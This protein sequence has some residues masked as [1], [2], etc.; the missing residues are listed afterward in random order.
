LKYPLWKVYTGSC[1]KR[2]EWALPE[3][4]YLFYPDGEDE[5]PAG[6]YAVGYV[7]GGRD[8]RDNL[9]G[10]MINYIDEHGY[11]IFGDA[12]EEYPLNEINGSD[13][14]GYLT[15]VLISVRKKGRK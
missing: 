8:K 15:R 5:R 7:R 2:G 4:Y 11:K 9:Y 3:R 1:V 12:Y 14:K 10:R 6:L 13:N